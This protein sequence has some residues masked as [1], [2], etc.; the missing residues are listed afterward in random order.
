MISEHLE[1]GDDH[2]RGAG[3]RAA[4]GGHLLGA[5]AHD[6]RGTSCRGGR[7]SAGAL[8]GTSVALEADGFDPETGRVWSVVVKGKAH[9]IAEVDDLMDTV[10]LA[11]FP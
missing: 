1:E 10:D 8:S 11:L 3:C 9:T 6:R 5:D 4:H 2:D 7:R